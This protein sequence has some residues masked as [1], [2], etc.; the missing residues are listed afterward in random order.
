MKFGLRNPSFRKHIAARTSWKRYVRRNLGLKTPCVWVKKYEGRP[1]I[2]L[3]ELK[4]L[5]VQ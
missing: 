1:V 4:D 2:Y 5:R 3:K